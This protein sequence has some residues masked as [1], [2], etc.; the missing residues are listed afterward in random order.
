MEAARQ[1]VS[2]LQRAFREARAKAIQDAQKR[3]II[4]A[5]PDLAQAIREAEA[6]RDQ[7]GDSRQLNDLCIAR[8]GFLYQHRNEAPSFEQDGPLEPLDH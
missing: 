3:W 7:V 6:L 1:G 2:S 4:K 8:W 5:Y